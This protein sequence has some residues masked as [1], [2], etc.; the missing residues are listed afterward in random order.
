MPV[1][2][3]SKP[4]VAASTRSSS[5]TVTSTIRVLVTAGESASGAVGSS[6]TISISESDIGLHCLEFGRDCI[7]QQCLSVQSSAKKRMIQEPVAGHGQAAHL[8]CATPRLRH[9]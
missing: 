3:L 7:E 6:T 5:E 4:S 1:R 8:L 9:Q 2:Q